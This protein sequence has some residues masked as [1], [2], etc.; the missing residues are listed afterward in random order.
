MKEWS[1]E[2]KKGHF[3]SNTCYVYDVTFCVRVYFVMMHWHFLLL[4]KAAKNKH[5]PVFF[6]FLSIFNPSQ[7]I[8]WCTVN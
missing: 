8:L 3:I 6:F 2:N 1:V 4:Q 7:I 5:K